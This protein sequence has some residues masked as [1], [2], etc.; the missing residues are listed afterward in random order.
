MTQVI[1]TD[2]AI[3]GSGA[4]GSVLAYYLA[5]ASE[6]V[7]LLER[8][9]RVEPDDMHGDELDSV[10]KL[11]KDAGAQTNLTADMFIIQGR[12]VG[13]STVLTNGACFYLPEDCR[14]DWA[15]RGFDLPADA[16]RRSFARTGSVLNVAPL[17]ERC[18]NPGAERLRRGMQAVGLKP[19]PFLKNFAHCVGCG[20]CNMGCRYGQ[21]LDASRT[22]IPMAE[23]HGCHVR[24]RSQAYRLRVER[25]AVR[26]LSCRDLETGAWF[27]V[28]AKRYVLAAGSVASP[29]LLLRSGI[30]KGRAGRGM[31]FN[32]GATTVAEYDEPIEA[33]RGDNLCVFSMHDEFTVEQLHNPP[34][35]FALSMPGWYD[36]HHRDLQ[37]YA[38]LSSAGVLIPTGN[39]GRVR[40][41]PLWRVSRRFDHAEV[42]FTMSDDDMALAR[43]GWKLMA[44]VFLASGAK[45]VVPPTMRYLELTDRSQLH[46]IDEALR[47]QRDIHGFGSAHPFGGCNAGDEPHSTCDGSFRVRGVD[48][49]FV[50]DASVFP[51]SIRVNPQWTI[52]S[53]AD[54]AAR[55]IGDVS[56]PDVIEEGPAYELR[57]QRGTTEV[58]R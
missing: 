10:V 39:Y 50:C 1:E 6:R 32:V 40:L 21:K 3:V 4:G 45:R 49:L 29:E 51:S 44:E 54:Y 25:G 9:R 22:W 8:G 26:E 28:R 18:F 33:W 46:R 57:R 11:F 52:M 48:N 14:E 35:T 27:T 53:V 7:L 17:D 31:S 5:R 24:P 13:G 30:A 42:E 2:F 36:R 16:L 55:A 43:K 38:Y 12:C 23:A 19:Q 41:S 37:R 15:N 58:A 56:V 47:W 34:M 20:Y